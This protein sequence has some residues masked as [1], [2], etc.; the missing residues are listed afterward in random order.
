MTYLKTNVNVLIKRFRLKHSFIYNPNELDTLL[1]VTVGDK[2]IIDIFLKNLKGGNANGNVKIDL[3][4]L[5]KADGQLKATKGKG[6]ANLVVE[7]VKAGNKIKTETQFT[8]AA[9]TYNIDLT[10]YPQFEKDNN[11]KIALSTHNK[12]TEHSVDSK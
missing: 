12:I 4:D 8:I 3:K 1:K 2:P 10:F 6:N 7:F 9:P 11:K 5:L